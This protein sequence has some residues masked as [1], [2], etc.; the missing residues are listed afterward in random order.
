MK[1]DDKNGIS[2]QWNQL[3]IKRITFFRRKIGLEYVY[4]ENMLV[5]ILLIWQPTNTF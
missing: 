2:K 5:K 3:N 1:G 4:Y